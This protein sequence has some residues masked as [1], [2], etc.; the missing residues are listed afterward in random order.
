MGTAAQ[1]TDRRSLWLASRRQLITATDAAKI[2]GKSPYG[3]AIDVYAEKVGIGEEKAPNRDMLRGKK[4]ERLVLETYAE[5]EGVGLVFW[6][7]FEVIA[8]PSLPIG[9]TLDAVRQDDY[10]P[11]E[12][13]SIRYK[14]PE[15]GQHG[16]DA[17]PLHFATQMAIQLAVL[18]GHRAAKGEP[19][20]ECADLPVEFT[21]QDY[22]CFRL[23]WDAETEAELIHLLLDFKARYIDKRVP[24]P[25]D[26]S[27]GY[28]T[29]LKH[30]FP[31][32]TDR[33]IVIVDEQARLHGRNVTSDE[34]AA[35]LVDERMALENVQTAAG[36]LERVRA[37]IDA[38]NFRKSEYES[39][40]KRFMADAGQIIG[41]GWE[42]TWRT[43]KPG[44]KTDWEA[45]AH[46]LLD[47][48]V[49]DRGGNLQRDF[50]EVVEK[51]T[52]PTKPARP[53][54]FKTE[55]AK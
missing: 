51:R 42:A 31:K 44:T 17:C 36:E 6:D 39:T 21:G 29:F 15:W 45:V 27:E 16:T 53:F 18:N 30:A 33:V 50:D 7:P 40:I 43:N 10:R 8:H 35:L 5:E 48:W 4:R 11:V 26:G 23:H 47:H 46:E 55:D 24:P 37:L 54:V 52:T 49:E 41:T 3:S 25:V 20:I 22:E 19:L 2:L 34:G 12:A 28:A 32:H 38:S 13:K 9:C 1:E 14:T